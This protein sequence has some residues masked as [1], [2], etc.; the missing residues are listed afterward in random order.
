MHALTIAPT[1]ASKIKWENVP[2][3]LGDRGSSP[4][5]YRGH[6]YMT[7]SMYGVKSACCIDVKT[8][9]I[10]WKQEFQKLESTSPI[11]V[12]GKVIAS[13]QHTDKKK[14]RITVMYRATPEKYEELGELNERVADFSSPAVAD[15]LLLL[16]LANGVACY[17]LRAR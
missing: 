5:L 3:G 9:Q 7:G 16:R 10:K 6:I 8:G 12:D 2:R 11:L 4:L 15:G 14:G 17:D 1:R 13:V